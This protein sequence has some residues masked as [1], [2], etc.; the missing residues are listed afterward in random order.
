MGSV[1]AGPYP[2]DISQC[3]GCDADIVW[4]KTMRG[5]K[6]PVNVMP[7]EPEFRGPNAGETGFKYGEHQAHF[8]TCPVAGE[9]RR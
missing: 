2:K 8:A 4:M 1:G 3:R 5:K 9:F 7:T 6:I